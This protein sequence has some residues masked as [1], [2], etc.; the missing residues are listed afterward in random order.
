MSI[1]RQ[2][3]SYA[4]ILYGAYLV[5]TYFGMGPKTAL[6]LL[7][8]IGVLQTFFFNKRWS[9][10]YTGASRGALRRYIVAYLLGYV[11]NLTMLALFVDVLGLPHQIVQGVLIF[12]VAI[13]IFLL[14]KYWVFKTSPAVQS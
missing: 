9:F 4:A 6:T 13:T 3:L 14:Q 2:F 7:Y 10:R 11:L 8:G 12:V 5:L 1:H